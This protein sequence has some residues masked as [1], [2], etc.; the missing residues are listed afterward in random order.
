MIK[1]KF[2]DKSDH[3]CSP[4]AEPVPAVGFS[5]SFDAKIDGGDNEDPNTRRLI[6]RP[7]KAKPRRS[8]RQSCGGAYRREARIGP[9]DFA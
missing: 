2:Y 4:N 6:L 3:C 5:E 7:E 1:R 8:T 9:G